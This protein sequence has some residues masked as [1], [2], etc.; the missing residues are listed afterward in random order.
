MLHDTLR[1]GWSESPARLQRQPSHQDSEVPIGG[2]GGRVG[3]S[4]L[5]NSVAM[6]YYNL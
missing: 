4:K 5:L 3:K 6:S 1:Q 2:G